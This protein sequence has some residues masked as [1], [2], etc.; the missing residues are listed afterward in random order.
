MSASELLNRSAIYV[1]L[2]MIEAIRVYKLDSFSISSSRSG[3]R[4]SSDG[5]ARSIRC[6]MSRFTVSY[7]LTRELVMR[8]A[9]PSA[10]QRG[11]SGANLVMERVIE[12]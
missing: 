9:Y 5:Y 3:H 4:L 12:R 11:Q 10:E 1:R 8:S 6:T 2:A 7:Y